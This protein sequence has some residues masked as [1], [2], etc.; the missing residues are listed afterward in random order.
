MTKDNCVFRKGQKVWGVPSCMRRLSGNVY[1]QDK[2]HGPHG[3]KW[4]RC[5]INPGSNAKEIGELEITGHIADIITTMG[6]NMQYGLKLKGKIP[7]NFPVI[8]NALRQ[9]QCVYDLINPI[10]Q[11]YNTRFIAWVKRLQQ[12]NLNNPNVFKG[13][14]K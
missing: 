4:V 3:R 2:R 1:G 13:V 8:E 10:Y 9:Q 12:Q 6:I 11:Q 14:I 5:R 7:D